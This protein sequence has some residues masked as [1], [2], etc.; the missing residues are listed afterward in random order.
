MRRVVL[1]AILVVMIFCACAAGAET[2]EY[3]SG[4]IPCNEDNVY[5]LTCCDGQLYGLFESGLYWVEPS[6]EKTLVAASAE[7]FP[8]IEALLSDNHSVYAVASREDQAILVQLVNADGTYVNESV[9]AAHFEPEEDVDLTQS[10]LRNGFLYYPVR[11]SQPAVIRMPLSGEVGTSVFIDN[12]VCFDVTEDGGILAQTRESSW[13]D[14]TVL[15][16]MV[17]P[18]TGEAETWADVGKAGLAFGIA[19][20][21]SDTVYL[22]TQREIYKVQKDGELAETGVAFTQDIVDFCLLPQGLAA[23]SGGMLKICSFNEAAGSADQK[24]VLSICG[25]YAEDEYFTDFYEAH[26]TAEIRPVDTD[27]EEPDER[28]IRDVLTQDPGIDIYILHNLNLLS[29]IKSKGYYA[30]LSQSE[31]IKE[32][33]GRMY[34]PFIGALTDGDKI[35]AFPHPYYVM[36]A[37][38]NYNKVLFDQLQLPVPTTWE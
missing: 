15:L 31:T 27:G 25:N 23:T 35:A 11:G 6:G 16:Q 4:N 3:T 33:V 22:M 34:A 10:V 18:E 29:D 1:T 9:F 20:A 17:S 7:L 32:K 38:V 36:F 14:D 37:S 8:G 2:V 21:D 5:A 28:F 30:D 12:L 24:L 19:C 26:P 13:P